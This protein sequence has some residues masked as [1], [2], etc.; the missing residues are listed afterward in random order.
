MNLC[1]SILYGASA[2][3]LLSRRITMGTVW[4]MVSWIV[5]CVLVTLFKG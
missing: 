3:G 1:I 2:I 4:A 5:V